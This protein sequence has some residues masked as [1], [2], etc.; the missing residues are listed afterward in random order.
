M[1]RKQGFTLVELLVTIGIIGILMGMSLPAIQMVREAARR[2][3]CLNNLKQ[4]GVAIHNYE[5]SR[6][7]LPP[8]RAADKFMTW[9]VYL[10]PY[11]EMNNLY[12][13]LETN[14]KYAAQDPTLVQTPM[15]M[16][17]CSSRQRTKNISDYESD[18]PLGAIGDYA[19]N[20]GTQRYFPYDA[21]AKF[22]EPVDGVFSSGLTSQNKV[23][24]DV[25]VSGERGRYSFASISDGTSNT[26]FVGEKYVSTFGELE[27]HGWG[28]GAIY[29]GDEPETFMR[30]G[31]YA[32]GLAASRTLELSPG[33]Y[34]IF[35]SGH[36]GAVNFV[37][38]DG[39]VHSLSTETDEE[40]LYRLCARNDGQ[41]VSID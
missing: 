26:L 12:D 23:V 40:T 28:D 38:G 20:A 25:L 27:S 29:N 30:I 19:G 34:P 15:T 33:E 1:R 17:L 2:T 13:Q 37:A 11:L 6:Q 18:G 32:M 10:M 8:S 24:N 5:S 39:S 4:I 36:P 35:G 16:M 41:P 3:H 21:W 9:P 14:R 31:G 22:E 7:F